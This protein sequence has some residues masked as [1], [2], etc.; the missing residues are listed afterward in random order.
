MPTSLNDLL[1][2]SGNYAEPPEVR[3]IKEFVRE[4]YQ[5]TVSVTVQSNQIIIGVNGAALAGTLRMR[6]H[7]L[8]QAAKT[9]K[10][11]VL[12]ISY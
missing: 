1:Q 6:L 3:I 5:E 2:A 12:R 8:K 11:L 7:E 9:D 10:Q 4:N